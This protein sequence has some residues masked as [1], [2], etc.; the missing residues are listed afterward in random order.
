MKR[1]VTGHDSHGKSIFITQGYPPR[2]VEPVPGIKLIEL[3]GTEEIPS[4]PDNSNDPTVDMKSFIPNLSGTRFRIFTVPPGLDD[5]NK[6]EDLKNIIKE[7]L[8][9]VPGLGD[10]HE[11]DNP[12]MH[13]TDTIDYIVVLSGEADLELDAGAKVHINAGDTVVQRGTRHAWRNKGSE[14]FVAAAVMI[15]AKRN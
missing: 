6:Q 3:W 7:S 2:I 8:H 9:K 11:V 15:G 1:V 5:P 13:T 12:G 14:P 4:L 10:A